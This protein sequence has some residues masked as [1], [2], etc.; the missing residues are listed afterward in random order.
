MRKKEFDPRP[1]INRGISYVD[2]R[3][4]TFQGEKTLSARVLRAE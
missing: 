3:A 2:I 4:R 1:E